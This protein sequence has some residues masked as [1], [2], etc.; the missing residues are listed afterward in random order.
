M[1]DTVGER[2][3]DDGPWTGSALLTAGGINS[4]SR[5]LGDQRLHGQVRGALESGIS[6]RVARATIRDASLQLC[7]TCLWPL[8]YK[9]IYKHIRVVYGS[10]LL[11]MAYVEVCENCSGIFLTLVFVMAFFQ[12]VK[13]AVV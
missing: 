7:R 12:L 4:S 11:K 5:R 2:E 1:S 6:T 10:V 3:A 8:P 9:G 13:I